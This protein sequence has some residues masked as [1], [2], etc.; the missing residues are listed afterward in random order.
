[1]EAY[2]AGP[3]RRS[4]DL[5]LVLGYTPLV[6]GFAIVPQGIVGFL[7]ATRGARIVR[8]VG[9]TS[10]LAESGVSAASA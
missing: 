4:L 7:A 1:M 5:Q 3:N 10:F 8:R 9:L 6:T 2:S